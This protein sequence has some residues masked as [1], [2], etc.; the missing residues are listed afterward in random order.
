MG[1]SKLFDTAPV[2]SRAGMF[3]GTVMKTNLFGEAK[4]E[5]TTIRDIEAWRATKPPMETTANRINFVL[6]GQDVKTLKTTD[7]SDV[8]GHQV[9]EATE[10]NKCVDQVVT[11]FAELKEA[12]NEPKNLLLKA[13]EMIE[14]A[15]KPLSFME[16]LKGVKRDDW[17]YVRTSVKSL[18]DQAKDLMKS[19]TKYHINPFI[20]GL[21]DAAYHIGKIS[22][23]LNNSINALDYVYD[24]A[25]D[26]MVKDL[27]LRR[28]E[29]FTKS[30]AL[31][32]MNKGQVDQMNLFCENNKQF[33]IELELTIKPLI[34]NILRTSLI[35]DTDGETAMKEIQTKLKGIL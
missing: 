15:S 16:K 11:D 20:E 5:D 24:R 28:K 14:N 1:Y 23:D 35:S 17:S 7:I 13:V 34:E 21:C 4:K 30:F 27:A 32:Q 26:A 31:M 25:D 8:G 19:G 33:G 10:A 2:V 29:M 6:R 3:G 9:E 12:L 22:D 18:I